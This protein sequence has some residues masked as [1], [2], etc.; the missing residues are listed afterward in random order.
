LPF[1]KAASPNVQVIVCLRGPV[2]TA[3]SVAA[4]GGHSLQFGLRLWEAH[5]GSLAEVIDDVPHIVTHYDAFHVDSER[6][7]ERPAS[8][9]GLWLP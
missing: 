7:L 4:R 6:E 9:V 8:L 1:W 2:A 5:Y 3:R